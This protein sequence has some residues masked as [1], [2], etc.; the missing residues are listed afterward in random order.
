MAPLLIFQFPVF[1]TLTS[2]LFDLI[3]APLFRG[4]G[5]TR[6]KYQL[7]DKHLDFYW[8]TISLYYAYHNLPFFSLLIILYILRLIG[9][10]IFY[11]TKKEEY[12]ILFP[13]FYEFVFWLLIF[14]H[15]LP[16]YGYLLNPPHLIRVLG[17][18][19]VIKMGQEILIHKFDSYYVRLFPEWIRSPQ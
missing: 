9:Q 14:V 11:I 7:I 12:F 1:S 2:W 6:L 15:T 4:A 5:F 17:I 18:L 16:S 10:L 13:S 19:F 8:Y 3:D